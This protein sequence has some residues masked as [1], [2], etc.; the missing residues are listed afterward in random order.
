MPHDAPST[1]PSPPRTVVATQQSDNRT[2]GPP[3]TVPSHQSVDDTTDPPL[4]VQSS[5][6]T[7]PRR[8]I[9]T[10]PCGRSPY[11]LSPYDLLQVTPTTKARP[12]EAPSW[13][14]HLT[15]PVQSTL[16]QIFNL[17]SPAR[18]HRTAPEPSPSP[19]PTTATTATTA[20]LGHD[21]SRSTT[22]TV[23]TA[24]SSTPP[25]SRAE[26]SRS[27]MPRTTSSTQ[28]SRRELGRYHRKI[29]EEARYIMEQHGYFDKVRGPPSC[30]WRCCNKGD[31]DALR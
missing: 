12:P 4:T 5:Q 28:T 30:S 6:E 13:N 22:R 16:S 18:A 19:S 27:P 1:P 11:Q 15:S 21:R 9:S 24:A 20:E 25:W 23:T 14:L 3:A 29:T 2:A 10:P 7:T 31:G 26:R 8:T 17:E